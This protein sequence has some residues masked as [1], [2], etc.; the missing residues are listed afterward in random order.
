MRPQRS[1]RTYRALMALPTSSWPTL[2]ASSL[3]KTP[4]RRRFLASEYACLIQTATRSH[5]CR[6]WAT[7][8]RCTGPGTVG[9]GNSHCR[10]SNAAP[11]SG[12]PGNREE[13]N[14]TAEL[15]PGKKRGLE[16]VSDARGVIA[17]L[18]IDQRGAMREL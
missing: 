8:R 12:L 6:F 5:I 7:L 2:P 10:R 16:A 11:S 14:M 18:A 1:L 15:T 9:K 13:K 17:A 4:T 3:E